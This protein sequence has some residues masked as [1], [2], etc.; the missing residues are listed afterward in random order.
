VI[1][2]LHVPTALLQEEEQSVTIWEREALVSA[3]SQPP[4]RCVANVYILQLECLRRKTQSV[5]VRVTLQLTVSQ[6]VRPGVEPNLGLLNRDFF[7]FKV[8]VLSWSWVGASCCSSGK[9]DLRHR[10]RLYRTKELGRISRLSPYTRRRNT[11]P[12]LGFSAELNDHRFIF[13]FYSI[14]FYFIWF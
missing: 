1:G 4:K 9:P 3:G 11:K 8:T 7:F 13:I 10:G 6:S 14:L 2:Q 12:L 5:R